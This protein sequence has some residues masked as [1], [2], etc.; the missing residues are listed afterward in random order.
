MALVHSADALHWLSITIHAA[1]LDDLHARCASSIA[2]D[3]SRV[4]ND[5]RLPKLPN[6]HL[7]RIMSAM[8]RQASPRTNQQH[9]NKQV[10]DLCSQKK[11]QEVKVDRKRNLLEAFQEAHCTQQ[12]LQAQL[13]DEI[14]SGDDSSSSSDDDSESE[15]VAAAV[16]AAPVLA[17]ALG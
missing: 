6:D 7:I 3:F 1:E 9:A 8:A 16:P 4:A 13:A 2:R 15:D 10:C 11:Q 14:L 17:A 12:D 5:A